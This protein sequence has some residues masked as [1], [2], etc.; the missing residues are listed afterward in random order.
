M[1]MKSDKKLAK[2]GNGDRDAELP[3]WWCRGA[4]H[5]VWCDVS[6]ADGDFDSD[7]GCLSGWEREVLLTLPNSARIRREDKGLFA[8]DVHPYKL[9]VYLHQEYREC[10][11]RVVLT[12][13]PTNQG[14]RYDLTRD[15]AEA[16][17]RA[18]LEAVLLIDGQPISRRPG[19]DMGTK[20]C[21]R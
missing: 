19:Q 11:P 14:T 17:G 4:A 8:C 7:R 15:E 2:T 13:D 3:Y 10:A 20:G 16:L 18:L 6:H 5:P 21:R 9:C 1:S 12:P